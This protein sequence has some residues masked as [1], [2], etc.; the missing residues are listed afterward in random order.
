MSTG[1]TFNGT[2]MGCCRTGSLLLLAPARAANVGTAAPS[3]SSVRNSRLTKTRDEQFPQP[4]TSELQ[5]EHRVFMV[6]GSIEPPS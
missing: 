6:L 4:G 2:R 3:V 5:P 1:W